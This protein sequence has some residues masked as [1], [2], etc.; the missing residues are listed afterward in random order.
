ALALEREELERERAEELAPAL[1]RD[2]ERLTRPCD[3]RS[4]EGGEPPLRGADPRLEAR[5]D[6][7]QRPL[8]RLPEPPVEALDP[9]RLE[10]DAA[11]LGRLDGEPG[12]LEPA[13]DPLPRLLGPCW[14]LLHEH[15]RGTRRERFTEPHPRADACRCGDSGHRPEERLSSFDGRERRRPQR[16]TRPVEQRRP[17]LES[18][19]EKAR[20]HWEHMF[21]RTHVPL[22]SGALPS[23][24][25]PSPPRL[26]GAIR[27]IIV[28][29]ENGTDVLARLAQLE[30][31]FAA[32]SEHLKTSIQLHALA[33]RKLAAFLVALTAQV[34][35]IN[36]ELI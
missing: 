12:V 21:Y 14:I 5:P 9:A 13:Q 8:E 23:T 30:E 26:V 28:P 6:G 25:W 29:V 34:M 35:K 18:R 2:D 27:A 1:V 19:D 16:E 20:D 22:S 4:R 17:K 33:T 32:L 7:R 31:D 36:E 11:R 24:T 3:A 10:V 15:E